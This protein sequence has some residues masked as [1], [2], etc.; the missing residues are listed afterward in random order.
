[1]VVCSRMLATASAVARL[2]VPR[3]AASDL[4]LLLRQLVCK[5]ACI[6]EAVEAPGL[7]L[8]GRALLLSLPPR[9]S[10]PRRSRR[11]R[12]AALVHRLLP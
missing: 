7:V 12:G 4:D 8:A 1:M 6:P 5:W 10:G 9:P 3:A 11:C 2:L